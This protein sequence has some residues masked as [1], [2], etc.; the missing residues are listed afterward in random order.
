MRNYRLMEAMDRAGIDIAELSRQTG[1]SKAA[2]GDMIR[3]RCQTRL[4]TRMSIAR[5]L[6]VEPDFILP[7]DQTALKPAKPAPKRVTRRT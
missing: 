5:A 1:I 7:A 4:S 2:I 6:G 3:L